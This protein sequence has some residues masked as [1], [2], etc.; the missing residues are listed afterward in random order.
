MPTMSLQPEGEVPQRNEETTGV[1][2]LLARRRSSRKRSRN[3]L[4]SDVESVS[5]SSSESESDH[6]LGL[7][8]EEI[9]WEFRLQRNG[10]DDQ[11]LET[12][13]HTLRKLPSLAS[14]R[15]RHK[16]YSSVPAVPVN[17]RTT[18]H[19]GSKLLPFTYLLIGGSSL[20]VLLEVLAMAPPGTNDYAE[21]MPDGLEYSAV[22]TACLHRCR[23]T[24]LVRH[25]AGLEPQRLRHA[26]AEISL[27]IHVALGQYAPAE[28]IRALLE[29]CPDSL[30]IK[31][32]K[33][34][35]TCLERVLW[36]E[37]LAD[38]KVV[39][40]VVDSLIARSS[41]GDGR[42]Q[43]LRFQHERH[44]VTRRV[45]EALVRLLPSFQSNFCCRPGDWDVDGWVYMLREM[46]KAGIPKQLKLE[47]PWNIRSAAD[48][49]DACTVLSNLMGQEST[50]L[51]FLLLSNIY[52]N[53]NSYNTARFLKAIVK[54][55]QAEGSWKRLSLQNFKFPSSQEARFTDL[56]LV[57]SPNLRR[58]TIYGVDL[59]LEAL[60]P[61][62]PTSRTSSSSLENVTLAWSNLA[63]ETLG[64]ILWVLAK[65]PVL[66][67]LTLSNKVGD[68]DGVMGPLAHLISQNNNL[69]E[70]NIASYCSMEEN[71]PGAIMNL[72][73][74]ADALKCNTS[75]R[76]IWIHW[77]TRCR[78]SSTLQDVLLHYNTTLARLQIVLDDTEHGS[79]ST[80]ARKMHDKIQHLVLL[81]S[82]G[83]G[84]VRSSKI[85]LAGFVDVL[86]EANFRVTKLD[87]LY[88]LLREC[89]DIWCGVL[90][91]EPTKSRFMWQQ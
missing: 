70:L 86:E 59:P 21:T 10:N 45:A 41:S 29:L 43:K 57:P 26:T 85:S 83:R 88:G 1:L 37:S 23:D 13:V 80:V 71:E 9:F 78:V 76:T 35:M 16:P 6:D 56:F 7:L 3:E 4:D 58:L 18:S 25:I 81:N 30:V 48:C 72:S 39:D 74:L 62:P 53:E 79:E 28:T 5:S 40:L 52:S 69:E 73:K 32:K 31:D 22:Y 61:P 8:L 20:E 77:P 51:S 47:L 66:K 65:M 24:D 38:P 67:V 2:A 15:F 89:P 17:P 36:H 44:R 75:L 49:E 54:G 11:V 14:R 84:K 42:P 82:F 91:A 90:P 68:W 19:S 33:T 46:A 60:G 12:I 64:R 87:V 63:E 34:I 55:M 27:P 50:D